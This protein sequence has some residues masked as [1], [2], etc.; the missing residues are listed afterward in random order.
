MNVSPNQTKTSTNP[1]KNQ[2]FPARFVW[3][4]HF[5]ALAASLLATTTIFAQNT[6]FVPGGT[7]SFSQGL[8]I[9]YFWGW[10]DVDR[11]WAARW[12]R[13]EDEMVHPAY[14]EW[15]SYVA[16]VVGGRVARGSIAASSVDLPAGKMR[17]YVV[18]PQRFLDLTPPI[19]P[20]DPPYYHNAGGATSVFFRENF[21]I[22]NV[23]DVD[24]RGPVV[25][26]PVKVT[27]QLDGFVSAGAGEVNQGIIQ[28]GSALNFDTKLYSYQ[29]PGTD[30]RAESVTGPL[31][32]YRLPGQ[33][34]LEFS[35]N[36]ELNLSITH[37]NSYFADFT[38]EG[39]LDCSAH[40]GGMSL[41][42][43]TAKFSIELPP[44][45]IFVSASGEFLTN[46]NSTQGVLDFPMP[47]GERA[48]PVVTWP[49]PT[50]IT[51]GTPL[52]S[53]QLN[54][55]AN[56][57]GEFTY[58]PAAGTLLSAG[59]SQTLW[60]QFVPNDSL[61][62]WNVQVS[63][64]LD[65]IESSTPCEGQFTIYTNDFKTTAEQWSS[66]SRETTPSGRQYLGQFTNETV[67][68]A[69]N[70]LPTHSIAVVEF[71]LYIIGSWDGNEDLPSG[72][73]EW[74]L[75]VDYQPA[76]HTTFSNGDTASNRQAYP[77]SYPGGDFP[78]RQGAVESNTLGY[79]PVG[80]TVYHF[81]V[82]VPHSAGDLVL[83]FSASGLQETIDQSWGLDNVAI[84]L[85]GGNPPL[86]ATDDA[87]AVAQGGDLSVPAP[88]VLA[89]DTDPDGGHLAA[90]LLS[91]PLHAAQFTLNADGSFTY[92]PSSSYEGADSFTYSV[93]G[94]GGASASATVSITV[95]PLNDAPVANAQSVTTL[96]DTAA[97]IAL[98]G[99]DVDGD[100]LTFAVLTSP[101]HG[102]L[103]GTA[104]N[105][106]YTPTA[107]FSGTESFTFKVNDGLV[108]SAPATV[109]ITVSPGN[110]APVAA[111]DAYTTDED[112]VLNVASPGVLGNDS[113]PD[114]G[115]LVRFSFAG[116]VVSADADF[117][118]GERFTG[119]YMVDPAA[120]RY[121]IADSTLTYQYRSD[122]VAWEISFPDRGYRYVAGS[123][124]TWILVGNDIPIWGDRYIADLTSALNIGIPLPSGRVLST[125]Q[126]DLWDPASA[127]AD[128][129]TDDSVQT[130]SINL[131]GAQSPA[132]RLAFRDGTQ[133]QL[134]IDQL[135][136]PMSVTQVNGQAAS[137][138]TPITL[139]SGATLRVNGNG[140]FSY[141]PRG[142]FDQLRSGESTTETFTYEMSDREG[143]TAS[144][145]VTITITGVNDAPLANAQSASTAEDAP[146]A[147]TL[148]GS[149]AEGDALSYT[150]LTS[151]A[152]G[153]LSGTA[154]NLTYTPAANYNGPDGFTFKVNDGMADSAPAVISITVTAVNDAP[155]AAQPLPLNGASFGTPTELATGSNPEGVA[156]GD[157]DGDGKLDVVTANY[158]SGSVSVF[159]NIASSGSL[160][161]SSFASRLD[162]AAGPGATGVVLADVDGDGKLDVVVA[163]LDANTISILRNKST[164]GSLTADSFDARVS[165]AT[166]L[167]PIRIAVSDVD[168]AGRPDL[169]VSNFRGAS[170][171]VLRNT[172]TAGN[173]SFATRVDVLNTPGWQPD[174]VA[175]Q[176]VDG[177]GKS[178]LVVANG[179][180]VSVYQNQATLG[181]ID[182]SSFAPRVDFNTGSGPRDVVVRDLDG[183]GK[184]DLAVANQG[185]GDISV[186]RNTSTAG[187]I[188]ANSFAAQVRFPGNYNT[189][190]LIARDL[191]SD[192][193]PDLAAVDGASHLSIFRNTSTAG[194]ITASSFA[195]KTDFSTGSGP[196]S[197]AAGDLDVD[198]RVDI[199]VANRTSSTI[200]IFQN[201]SVHFTTPEDEAVSITLIGEDAETLPASLSYTIVTP[202]THGSL[203]GTAQNLTYTPA[204]NYNG[205]DSFTFRVNDGTVDSAP[206]AVLISVT[207]VN[208]APADRDRTVYVYEDQGGGQVQPH[209]DVDGD[210]ISYVVVT[211]PQH[212]T[213][214][215]QGGN[216]IFRPTANYNG[217]DSYTFK[218][219]DGTL[220]SPVYTYTILVLPVNDAPAVSSAIPDQTAVYG[221]AFSATVPANT[222]SD[223]DTAQP[224]TYGASDMPP[225]IL[226]D[227]GTRTF[228]GAPTVPGTF[229]IT[230]TAT[231]DGVPPLSASTTFSLVV[232][233]ATPLVTWANPADS[234]Q[235]TPLDG[236]QLNAMASFNGA[237]VVGTFS[238]NP[239]AGTLLPVGNAQTLS[240]TF[241]PDNAVLY[242]SA[243]ASV[244]INVLN[245][246]PT[247]ASLSPASVV[248]ASPAFTLIVEGNNFDPGTVV[249]WNDTARPTTYIS[250]SQ[251]TVQI[252]AT[253]LQVTGDFVTALV[254]VTKSTGASSGAVA[255]TIIGTGVSSAV[256]QVQSSVA[257]A[258]E[259]VSVQTPPTAPDSAGVT[260]ALENSTGT[261]PATVTAATY[262]E[263][264][265]PAAAFEAGGGFVD[266]QVSGA[267]PGDRLSSSFY[268]PQ[269]V[270]GGAEDALMLKFFNGSAWI[271]VLSTG[272]IAPAKNTQDNLDGT[273]SGGR[274]QVLF[275]NTSTPQIT[276]LNGT[277]F[278]VAVPDTTQPAVTCPNITVPAN[279]N[280]LVPV[281]YPAPTVSDNIDPAPRVTYSIPSGSGFPIGATVVTCTAT[282]AAGN[283]AS[284]T[285]TV[286][287]ASLEFDGF[288]EPIDGADTT[289][290]SYA[291]PARTLKL[292]NKIRISFD[293]CGCGSTADT[294]PHRC[295]GERHSR[296]SGHHCSGAHVTTGIHTLQ[297]IKWTSQTDSETPLD[298][299]SAD[300]RTEGNQFR[301][302][303]HKWVFVL[304][305]RDTGMSRGRWQIVATLSDGSQHTAWVQMK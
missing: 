225:G 148:T 295:C 223:E 57:P 45:Y 64:L 156:I 12:L 86:R 130:T 157:L 152:H 227:T 280:L 24:Q 182:A 13:T 269:I 187:T 209:Q 219:T 245:A 231:D 108:D 140:S 171:S 119:F 237:P 41:A 131:A 212:G 191:N 83:D 299:D 21:S 93:I 154:P 35:L 5:T 289:G 272:G 105:L 25:N 70:E 88:G 125:T 293:L 89:N 7:Y 139:A 126:L 261:T 211:P 165:F 169:A 58:T 95:T 302:V 81:R 164:S 268:Y 63:A 114:A 252:P 255:F 4:L 17:A 29:T 296:H 107:G 77:G 22:I 10:N 74:Q 136:G 259:T 180:K 75:N 224:L 84:H 254:T 96:E 143:A 304:D 283:T 221:A 110:I 100:A 168:G 133:P 251:V 123:A 205:P 222:F 241:T 33:Q 242:A 149:D 247:I 47:S 36:Y 26:V 235:G 92:A 207:P 285:F 142:H 215:I 271:D 273:V 134:T 175:L 174:G 213:V 91:G 151:P 51:Y 284:T 264:P 2:R 23:V 300:A 265:T 253:D 198:G 172:S 34:P 228:S 275:D 206:A 55:T 145:T 230:V 274:F 216:L 234:S 118:A 232:A 256:G 262:T 153:I 90:A 229:A 298:A 27:I 178:D 184:P 43:N 53:A 194:S 267:D 294:E 199:V 263:N 214:V 66:L 163:N 288:A 113:D 240:A 128:L 68:F 236:T 286:T 112:T 250:P 137:V 200:S 279:V 282:D 71:D 183:D 117:S 138:N 141:D 155:I 204:A 246:A 101:A 218:A 270:T 161:A 111:N 266:L 217:P 65:V 257:S 1:V 38:I 166:G 56:V 37:L 46:P 167:N 59:S 192:G 39:S 103:T 193:K 106:T 287:R 301:L 109:S 85:C 185:S 98:T 196:I 30:P 120:M 305:T 67:T 276:E 260:A 291:N 195:P 176:D 28:Y 49:T 14:A 104:P 127:G 20:D 82:E 188:D 239:P 6:V 201:V 244:S 162:V 248:A 11:Q 79:S 116:H 278:A 94:I 9:E 87:Y 186:L 15:S 76:I 54:A 146:L 226:F 132:G 210:P 135:V 115:P 160:S 203:T 303:G 147:I 159:L 177:D 179:D 249:S 173:I 122:N 18:A 31:N 158:Q 290:G 99:S 144:A 50:S 258:G 62:Y 170:V 3:L 102:N 243:N 202:P 190:R 69:L 121:D 52:S 220:E 40:N 238:Y 48:T 97:N 277:V 60:V 73:D 292:G 281:T 80:D 233:K 61:N 181:L 208:D 150:V 124:Y 16:S 19:R 78:G 197:L 72:P 297:V 44:G 32:L 129:L 189:V 8:L 42:N